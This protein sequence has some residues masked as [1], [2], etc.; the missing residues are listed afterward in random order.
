MGNSKSAPRFHD[1]EVVS[2]A[3]KS[4]LKVYTAFKATERRLLF[5]YG[6]SFKS[7]PKLL[8]ILPT[9]DVEGPSEG[10]TLDPGKEKALTTF[11]FPQF[12]DRAKAQRHLKTDFVWR[13]EEDIYPLAHIWTIKYNDD[14]RENFQVLTENPDAEMFSPEAVENFYVAVTRLFGKEARKHKIRYC[15]KTTRNLDLTFVGT[16]SQIKQFLETPGVKESLDIN[17]VEGNEIHVKTI[18]KKGHVGTKTFNLGDA[19]DVEQVLYKR[20]GYSSFMCIK[21]LSLF[22]K[23]CVLQGQ[24]TDF[25]SSVA[26]VYPVGLGSEAISTIPKQQS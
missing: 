9:G 14:F 3:F 1:K 20:N 15:T 10:K 23:D 12:L 19:D 25:N 21:P 17:N 18:D 2:C 6:D 7:R 13:K 5:V 4:E 11:P 8:T 26:P 24:V 16:P 22:E